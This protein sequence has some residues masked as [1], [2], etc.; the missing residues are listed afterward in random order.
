M[1]AETEAAS[2]GPPR[3]AVHPG[4]QNQPEFQSQPE[5]P[6]RL[7][8]WLILLASLTIPLLIVLRIPGPVFFSGDA[9]IKLLLVQQLLSPARTE[10]PY[11]HHDLLDDPRR[12]WV[13]ELWQDP[14]I[15]PYEPPFVYSVP[16]GGTAASGTSSSSSNTSDS[17]GIRQLAVFPL[18]F[19]LLSTPGYLLFGVPGLRLLPLLSIGLF[20]W[21]LYRCVRRLNLDTEASTLTLAFALLASPIPLYGALVWEH[22]PALLLTF[23]GLEAVLSGPP[24][25][26]AGRLAL[27]VLT[28]LA[29]WL[30]PEAA[31]FLGL[32][33]ILWWPP[34]AELRRWLPV[35]L[36]GGLTLIGF[37][38]ANQGLYGHPLGAHSFQLL[39]TDDKP[40][41]VTFKILTPWQVFTEHLSL[42]Q[43]TFPT[44]LA[45][46]LALGSS[47]LHRASPSQ[48]Y[49]RSQQWRLATLAVLFL[50][51]VSFLVPNAGGKQ[52]GPRY[53]LPILPALALLAGLQWQNARAALV[54]VP[55]G[56]SL[57]HKGWWRRA[58]SVVVLVL[59]TGTLL[60][61]LSRNALAGSQH[62][63][64][65]FRLRIY[66]GLTYLQ[67]S[68]DE[69]IVFG[70]QWVPQEMAV[71][72][73]RRQFLRFQDGPS[74]HRLARTLVD[75][76][77]SSVLYLTN[78]G[79]ARPPVRLQLSYH[80]GQTIDMR[81]EVIAQ[82]GDTGALRL[83]LEPWIE[84]P[85]V[86]Q[87]APN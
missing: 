85:L 73:H 80:D 7:A 53:L 36:A 23:L 14:R 10:L 29:V 71:E 48:H 12:A 87:P 34:R 79:T 26:L 37:V 58:A 42:L 52:W 25:S 17:D 40:L 62:L 49:S 84:G 66:P 5:P 22:A 19:P 11:L 30:R 8:A 20:G 59:F 64:N 41:P 55:H 27:G 54:Q 45:C 9:G 77:H 39:A 67:H 70:N 81:L 56:A 78:I 51:L 76:G 6:R 63:L 1:A 60:L 33:A 74:L 86:E 61:G 18:L 57:P 31:L 65:D 68:D 4:S 43:A 50:I 24:R 21:V 46:L 83:H 15:F 2:L 72:F 38:V 28:G 3:E 44:A 82:L 13:A 47:W 75:H 16:S 69:V 32:L 35:G